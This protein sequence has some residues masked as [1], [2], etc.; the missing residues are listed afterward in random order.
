MYE[1]MVCF[2]S[3]PM[4]ENPKIVAR[5]LQII[6]GRLPSQLRQVIKN[7]QNYSGDGKGRGGG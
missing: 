6:A 5:K 1:R 3:H 2:V 7:C 4:N